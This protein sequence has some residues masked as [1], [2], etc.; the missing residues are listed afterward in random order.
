MLR[1]AKT[2]GGVILLIPML[3]GCST[4]VE[5]S[6]QTVSVITEPA[7]ASCELMR[8]GQAIGF[9]NPTPGSIGLEKSSDNVAVR[10]RKEGHFDGGGVLASGFQDMTFGNILFGGLIGVAVDAAS[11]AMHEYPPSVTVVL[12]P[13]R[14]SD[15]GEREA[16]FDRQAKRIES[17]AATAIVEARTICS[18]QSDRDCDKLVKAIEAE[19]DARLEELEAQKTE[20]SME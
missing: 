14:F 10:C 7:G 5:G 8:E 13:K 2:V 17:E 3:Q 4:I 1:F 16:F 6:D 20:T 12:T 9:V 19:R 15:T 11:G 18:T